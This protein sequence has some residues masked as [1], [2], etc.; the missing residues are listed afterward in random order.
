[1]LMNLTLKMF[2]FANCHISMLEMHYYVITVILMDS[3]NMEYYPIFIDLEKSYVKLRISKVNLEVSN[4][5][6]WPGCH[7]RHQSILQASWNPWSSNS[8]R[9][10]ATPRWLSHTVLA[11]ARSYGK[12]LTVG[13]G[14]VRF[15]LY[16]LLIPT[17]TT[18]TASV[19]WRWTSFFHMR[20]VR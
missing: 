10:R 1:M 14:V 13:D 11:L 16:V 2:L 3:H 17:W 18:T 20:R 6:S 19:V 7:F 12:A 15:L 4:H 8:V 9:N 5:R